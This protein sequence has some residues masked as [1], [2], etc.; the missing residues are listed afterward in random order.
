MP[1]VEKS[2]TGGQPQDMP[3]TVVLV[4]GLHVNRNAYQIILELLHPYFAAGAGGAT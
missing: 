1:Y 2:N 3:G 4:D